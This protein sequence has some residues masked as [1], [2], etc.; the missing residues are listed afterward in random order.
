[1]TVT[2]DAEIRAN[3]RRLGKQYPKAMSAAL[4]KLA[5]V[6]IAEATRRAPVEF[7]V[8]RSSAYVSPPDDEGAKANV[9]LGFGTVYAVPQHERTDYHHPKGGESK[10]LEKA[11]NQYAPASLQLLY[12]WIQAMTNSEGVTPGSWG[13]S[14]VNKAPVVGNS[15]R[16]TPSQ[17]KRLKRAA[18]NVRK[19]TG[20]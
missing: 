13:G 20:R 7:G 16:K 11:I 8:L 14:G 6:I 2:G 15:N 4:Y 5:V 18:A 10:Y 17:G 3:I 12:R 1:M 19:K 9:E